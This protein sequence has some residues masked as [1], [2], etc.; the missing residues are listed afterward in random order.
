MPFMLGDTDLWIPA[1]FR[2][3]LRL[4][5]RKWRGIVRAFARLDPKSI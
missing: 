2:S 5:A 3:W 1:R 4:L